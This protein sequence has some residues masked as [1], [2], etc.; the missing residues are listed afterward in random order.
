VLIALFERAV[1]YY[2]TL[3]NVNAYH[4]PGVEAGKKAAATMLETQGKVLA[5]LSATPQTAEDIAKKT[6]SDRLRRDSVPYS[7]TP[8]DQWPDQ[9]HVGCADKRPGDGDRSREPVMKSQ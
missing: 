1:G 5:A 9:S 7:G 4:Q 3:V 6:G 8:V 2:G